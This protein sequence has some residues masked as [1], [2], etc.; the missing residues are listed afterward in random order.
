MAVTVQTPTCIYCGKHSILEI[1]DEEFAA[2]K[3]GALI[4]DA[5]PDR[6]ADFRETVMTGIHPEC[7]D[8]IMK[9]STYNDEDDID[10]V[11]EVSDD[12]SPRSSI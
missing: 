5:L 6:D 1:T 7:W 11:E 2:L 9:E 4:T 8:I 3:T 12:F 10:D